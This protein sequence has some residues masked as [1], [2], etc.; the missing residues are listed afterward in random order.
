M[1]SAPEDLTT[2]VLTN[3]GDALTKRVPAYRRALS[4]EQSQN[5]GAEKQEVN[6]R[7]VMCKFDVS[8]I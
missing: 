1:S 3:G 6:E 4:L 7:A 2:R 5:T 8:C